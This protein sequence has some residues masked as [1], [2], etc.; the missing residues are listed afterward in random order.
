MLAVGVGRRRPVRKAVVES[1]LI[2][3]AAWAAGIG[4]GYGFVLWYDHAFLAPKAILI[5]VLDGYALALVESARGQNAHWVYLK[6]GKISR[7][8]VK[9][10]SFC[11][12]IAMEHAAPGNI[13]PDFPLINKSMNLSYAGN[14]L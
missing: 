14:D 4:L 8:K 9:T 13:V 10:A 12:W 3:C 1:F 2:A 5:R 7:Y 11:N 6:D